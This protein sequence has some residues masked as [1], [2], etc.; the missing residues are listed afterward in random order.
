MKTGDK[1]NIISGDDL[2]DLRD[3]IQALLQFK[4]DYGII[5]SSDYYLKKVPEFFE[6]GAIGKCGARE[7]WLYL[8]P[9]GH[10]KICPD[11]DIYAHYKNYVRPGKINCGDCW[12]TCR[13]ETEVP[14]TER[15]KWIFSNVLTRADK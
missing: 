1:K 14:F 3:I 5:H 8:T 7:S 6:K 15:L 2:D 9:D 11:K 12:Y 10:L 4:H 13:G